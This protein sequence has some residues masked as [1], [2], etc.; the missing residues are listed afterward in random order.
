MRSNSIQRCLRS[1]QLDVDSFQF[2]VDLVD[3]IQHLNHVIV[4]L[5]FNVMLLT[6]VLDKDNKIVCLMSA[7]SSIQFSADADL[8][9][10]VIEEQHVRVLFF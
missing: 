10:F 3:I 2:N 5:D 9:H 8:D 1:F 7:Y 6:H 4:N